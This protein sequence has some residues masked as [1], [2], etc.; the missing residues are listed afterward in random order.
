M[1]NSTKL[2]QNC[3]LK[4]V[5]TNGYKLQIFTSSNKLK[6]TI[7]TYKLFNYIQT[8]IHS[9]KLMKGKRTMDNKYREK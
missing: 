2:E 6:Y 9:L 7:K 8:V 3:K 5:N 4:L 1:Q